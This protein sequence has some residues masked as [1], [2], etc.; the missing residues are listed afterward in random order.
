MFSKQSY[1]R[2]LALTAIG[3]GISVLPAQAAT[4]TAA[5]ASLTDVSAAIAA[6]VDGDTVN[7]PAGSATWG[8][9]LKLTKAI[10]L[11]GAGS[12]ST[13]ISANGITMM[14]ISLSA[15]KP[16]RVSG[17][18]FTNAGG[19]KSPTLIIWGSSHTGTGTPITSLRVDH[20]NF[21]FGKR[22]VN[23]DGYVYGVIDH[24]T[25]VNCD[26]GVGITGDDD[27][28]WKRPIEPGSINTLCIE[29]NTFTI[30]NSTPVAPN[31]QIYHQEGTRTTIRR[32]TF[33]GRAY[34]NGSSLFF[35]CHGNQGYYTGNTS[36]D[37]RGTVL[38]EFYNNIMKAYKTYRMLYIR[39]G[40][41]F[42]YNNTMTCDS[43]SA[44]AF[45]LTEEEAWQTQFFNPL[46]TTWPAQDQVTNSHFW[47]NTMNGA[48]V[49]SV[50]LWNAKDST[51][52][53]QGRDYWM[54]APASGN[55][56]YPYTALVYPHPLVTA[57][58]GGT[59]TA[60]SA[61]KNFKVLAP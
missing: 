29:D 58:D 17:I 22:A 15:N 43:G 45:A 23:P 61:P 25:F 51:F 18:N 38:V 1:L 9:T 33:D 31:E 20:C 60:P 42:A 26:I 8:S 50:T 35:D 11:K 46:K 14:V 3:L 34:T 21:T 53:Q 32:N 4:R 47:N 16:V 27:Y 40:T 10:T 55:K 41:T 37:F 28:A 56:Y 12:G 30:N 7:I 5:S 24:N 57:Q 54:S 36:T 48:A 44:T 19:T 52:I 49:T 2:Y 6:S 59:A 39:A 13:K